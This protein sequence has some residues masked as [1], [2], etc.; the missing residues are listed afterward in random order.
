MEAG[1]DAT[2]L[3]APHDYRESMFSLSDRTLVPTPV[4]APKCLGSQQIRECEEHC[5]AAEFDM[6]AAQSTTL[7]SSSEAH[8]VARHDRKTSHLSAY[9]SS[10][11]SE[12]SL[13]TTSSETRIV[14]KPLTGEQ[15]V[16]STGSHNASADN[17]ELK[18]ALS[19]GERELKEPL[20]SSAPQPLQLSPKESI[21]LRR[22]SV[23]YQNEKSFVKGSSSE[24]KRSSWPSRHSTTSFDCAVKEDVRRSSLETDSSGNSEKTQEPDKVRFLVS[25]TVHI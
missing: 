1:I 10:V 18:F 4:S 2:A 21:G 3:Q 22:D 17:I 8:R 7:S 15:G 13:A 20:A 9:S 16:N 23:Q 5:V 11:Y 25:S 12:K 14:R 24:V 6:N 19:V